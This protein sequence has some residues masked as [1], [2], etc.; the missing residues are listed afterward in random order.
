MY[1]EVSK[2][3]TLLRTL[4]DQSFQSK[5]ANWK[6]FSRKEHHDVSRSFFFSTEAISDQTMEAFQKSSEWS[7]W[8]QKIKL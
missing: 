1:Q 8:L 3:C 6:T 4:F 5:I 7:S 2:L